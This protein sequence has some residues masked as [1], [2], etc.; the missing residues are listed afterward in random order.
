MVDEFQDTSPLQLDIFLKL[1]KIA[2]HSIWVGDP[3][4]SIY[5]F[6]G[7]EP[8]LMHA[9]IEHIGIRNEDILKDSW[10]SRPDIVNATN[11]IFTKA[12]QDLP[13]E[14]V[15]LNA[16][17]KDGSLQTDALI[18]WHFQLDNGGDKRVRPNQEWF[19]GCVAETIKTFLERNT[20]ILPKGEKEFRAAQAGDIAI[21]CRTN[22][23]C[24]NMA[25]A[26]HRVGIKAAISRTGLLETAEVKLILAV[27]RYILNKHDSLSVAEILLLAEKIELTDIIEHRLNYLAALGEDNYNWRWAVEDNDFIKKISDLRNETKEL[28]SNE[29][30]NLVLDELDLRRIIA[31]WGNT[32]QRLDNVDVIRKFSIQYENACNR[33]HT[34][35]SLGGFLLWLNE[36]AERELDTQSSGES[37]KAVNILTYHKSKGLEYPIVILGSLEQ[38]L[39]DNV[40][41]IALESFSTEGGVDLDNI[42]GNRWLR[43]WVNPYADQYRNTEM[44][45]RINE[46]AVKAKARLDALAEEARLMYV[47]I[48][49]ARD[50][51][52]FP[53]YQDGVTKWLNRAWHHGNEEF[54]VLDEGNETP[55]EW[56]QHYITKDYE[57]I[58][59]EKTHRHAGEQ[60]EGETIRFIEQRTGKATYAAYKI[61]VEKENLNGYNTLTIGETEGYAPQLHLKEDASAPQVAKAFDAFLVADNPDTPILE[62]LHAAKAIIDRFDISEDIDYQQIVKQANAFF[63]F[64]NKKYSIQHITT[65]YPLRTHFNNRLFEGEMDFIVKTEGG[66]VLIQNA[67][68]SNSQKIKTDAAKYLTKMFLSKKTVESVFKTCNIECY[69]HCTLLGVMVKVG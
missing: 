40:F 66:I 10:R 7:A 56:Q 32:S 22:D 3:K 2:Q 27:L 30:L 42:L 43:F 52:I 62:R 47:G 61:E 11:A 45:E 64:L 39:R 33:L 34:A 53:T 41:G 36:L 58:W 6:R 16:K 48:T 51:L 50:Y 20:L 1:S 35:A 12:F 37:A 5:G 13:V 4:Q 60:T 26:L 21:L 24:K 28:S 23:Q 49:R 18:H 29:I 55:F 68:L 67:P 63:Y 59:F 25:N 57:E 54:P 8:R 15:A 44:E 69:V 9:I 31:T 14:Q 46:S 38:G 19:E 65:R 17:R